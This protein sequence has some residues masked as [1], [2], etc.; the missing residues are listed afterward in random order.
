MKRS[1]SIAACCGAMTIALA[2]QASARDLTVTSWGGPYQ[3]A[4]RKIYFD[5]FAAKAGIK[6]LDDSWNGGYG[7]IQAKVKAGNPN[8]DVVQV[9]ADELELGCADG[10]YE[11]IDWKKIGNKDDWNETAIHECGVGVIVWDTPLAYDG[12]KIKDGP[13]GWADFWDVNKYPGKRGMR[14]GAKMTLEFALMADGV[15][16]VDVYKVLATPEGVDRAFKKLDELKPSIIW[17]ESASQMVQL[18]SSG[19]VAMTMAYDGRINNLNKNEKRNLKIVWPGSVY[20]TDFWVILKGAENKEK[21]MDFIAFASQPE[22]MVKLPE[23]MAYGLPNK[24]AAAK[25]PPKLPLRCRLPRTLRTR[26]RSIPPSGSTT[27]K[28]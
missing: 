7:L 8:W 6:V 5:P 17:W 4:Q 2:T 28:S 27:T 20:A 1:V 26:Y 11:P 16:N 25:I 15:A 10:L 18:L 21:A 23:I 24:I 19:E 3:E 13:K 22:N 14:K 9:E 12:D